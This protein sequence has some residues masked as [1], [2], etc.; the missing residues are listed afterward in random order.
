[1]WSCSTSFCLLSRVDP[2]FPSSSFI[3]SSFIT[4]KSQNTITD[5]QTPSQFLSV[6][7]S[8]LKNPN[9]SDLSVS[10]PFICKMSSTYGTRMT[11]FEDSEKESEYGYVRKVFFDL[12]FL[13]WFCFLLK[14]I[15]FHHTLLA[16]FLLF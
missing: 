14:L 12:L 9:Q 3:T 13:F 1:M 6:L 8:Q 5:R 11:T 16:Q 2:L 15:C 7:R 4:L 10:I